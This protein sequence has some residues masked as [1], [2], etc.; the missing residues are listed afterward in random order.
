[1]KLWFSLSGIFLLIILGLLYYLNIYRKPKFSIESTD[2]LNKTVKFKWSGEDIEINIQ[3]LHEDGE[4]L[5][6]KDF[7]GANVLVS[8]E[9]NENKE[10]IGFVIS[11]SRKTGEP[12]QSELVIFNI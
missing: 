4:E 12:Y 8:P 5:I 6:T 9:E 3:E 7:R 10:L 1:M 2:N 11:A